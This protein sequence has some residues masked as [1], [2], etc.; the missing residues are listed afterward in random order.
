MSA[1]LWITIFH[2]VEVAIEAVKYPSKLLHLNILRPEYEPL[3]D[4][5]M[6]QFVATQVFLLSPEVVYHNRKY[7]YTFTAP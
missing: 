1:T 5:N 6:C 7:L 2:P 3:W 4:A